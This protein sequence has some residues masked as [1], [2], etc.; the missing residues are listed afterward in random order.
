[1]RQVL[2]VLVLVGSRLDEPKA[3]PW[4]RNTAGSVTWFRTL[5][6]MRSW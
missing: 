1:M 6:S 2:S 4:R 3:P 5:Q